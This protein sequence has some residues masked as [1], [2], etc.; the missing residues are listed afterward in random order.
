MN[1]DADVCNVASQDKRP[2]SVLNY[3][4]KMLTF[5]EQFPD[6]LVFGD[7][8][9]INVDDSPVFAYWRKSDG[10]SDEEDVLVVLNMTAGEDFSFNLPVGRTYAVM[11]ST[12][13][14]KGAGHLEGD[15]VLNLSAYEGL[16]LGAKK[17]L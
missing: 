6:T 1:S 2:D 16:V 9:P 17:Q 4:R 8:E 13:S 5:R 11:Q 3:W 12:A 15:Q 10:A 7:F 14:G